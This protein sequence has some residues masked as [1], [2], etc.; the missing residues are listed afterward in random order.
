MSGSS[1]IDVHHHFYP[2]QFLGVANAW[3]AKHGL[4]SFGGRV[5]NWTPEATLADMDSAGTA[6]AIL[7]LSSPE[8][9]WFGA[10]PAK[11]PQIARACNDYAVATVR[12]HP[13]RFGFFACLPLP[14]VEASLKEIAYAFDVLHA[15]GVGMPTSFGDVWPGDPRFAPVFAELNRRKAIVVFHPYAPNCCG[16][17]SLQDGLGEAILEFPYDTGRCIL[18]LLFGATLLANR[19]IC[20]T[21]SHGGGPISVLAGRISR[22]APLLQKNY[23]AVTPHGLDFELRRLYYDTANAA[24]APTMSA[25][26]KLVPIS[27]ILFGTDYPYLTSKDNADSLASLDLVPADLAAIR[28]GNA[29]RLFPRLADSTPPI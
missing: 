10:E 16:I 4:P 15:D 20:F 7:S 13:S 22:L 1:A 12:A 6:I 11:I 2:P 14:D 21:F 25:L 17:G 18:S 24:Y 23:A 5:G 29:E 9:V 19:D 27:Q 28:R 8:G 3:Q 26:T